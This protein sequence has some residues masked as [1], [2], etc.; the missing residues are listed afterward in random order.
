VTPHPRGN[1]FAPFKS[2]LNN[3]REKLKKFKMEEER[4]PILD[5]GGVTVIGVNDTQESYSIVF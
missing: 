3:K 2:R 5:G 1:F 4:Q